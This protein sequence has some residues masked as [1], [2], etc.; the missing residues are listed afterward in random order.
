MTSPVLVTGARGTVGSGVVAGLRAAG[1]AVRAAG[2]DPEQLEVPDDVAR[3]R[4]DLADPTSFGPALDGVRAVFC[5][6]TGEL[7]GFAAAAA[8]AG[9][10]HVV[11]LSSESVLTETDPV[12]GGLAAHH[13]DAEVALRG[14]GLPTTALRPGAFDRNTFQWW[15][16]IQAGVVELPYPHASTSPI[17]ERD[18]ADV[19]VAALLGP[20]ADE[21]PHLTGPESMTF[22]EQV[23]IVAT[24]LGRAVEV[25]DEGPTAARQ[26]MTA[27]VPGPV[28]DSLLRYWAEFAD[29]PA[30]ITTEVAERTG[31]PGRSYASWVADTL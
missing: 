14:A 31:H 10:E 19:A 12:P 26:R 28:V 7:D 4:L 16:G 23:G 21:S 29:G 27:F 3:V 9:V 22:A 30:P 20:P 15:S 8:R 24:H 6:V 11:L 18:I 2:R 17:D 1:V 25:R 13:A 5:Y